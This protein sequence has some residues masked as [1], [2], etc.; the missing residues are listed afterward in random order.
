MDPLGAATLRRAR[1]VAAGADHAGVRLL[2]DGWPLLSVDVEAGAVAVNDLR[3]RA[4]YAQRAVVGTIGAD[5]ELRLGAVGGELFLLVGEA[6][7]VFVTPEPPRCSHA[8]VSVVESATGRLL[9]ERTVRY[10]QLPAAPA[11]PRR[12]A[13]RR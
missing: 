8:E 4:M 13:V 10:R 2:L 7:T 9:L 5:D 3:T 6:A 12:P 11:S 1:L